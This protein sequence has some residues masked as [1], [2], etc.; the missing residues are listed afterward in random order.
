VIRFAL[1][2]G[3]L[4]ACGPAA[5][6]SPETPTLEVK[7][8]IAAAENA[9]RQRRHDL[10]REHYEK[11]VAAAHDPESIAFARHEFAETL[12][13]WGEIGAAIRQL[14]GA[15]AAKPDDAGAW[16]DLGLA[17]HHE[18]DGPGAVTALRRARAIAPL[19]PRPRIAL[20]ALFWAQCQ[21]DRVH[22]CADAVAEYRGLLELDLPANVRSKVRWALDELAKP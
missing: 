22:P 15:V 14:E 16:H 12:V 20:A 5:P 11:A 1:V 7:A 8:E 10:A 21:R 3:A 17:R 18:G 13:T 19:D 9:E 4:A 6:K 2:A